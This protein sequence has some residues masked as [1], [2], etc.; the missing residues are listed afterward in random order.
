ML[1]ESIEED[2]F[3]ESHIHVSKIKIILL[4]R[5]LLRFNQGIIIS[6]FIKVFQVIINSSCLIL[7]FDFISS[8]ICLAKKLHVLKWQ[9]YSSQYNSFCNR[10]YLHGERGVNVLY[11]ASFWKLLDGQKFA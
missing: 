10:V 9:T 5:I 1:M 11:C 8:A 3:K 7:I 6:F 4:S 2:S